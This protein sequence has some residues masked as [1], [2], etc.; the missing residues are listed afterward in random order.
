[1]KNMVKVI[2]GLSLVS[3]RASCAASA[4]ES[5]GTILRSEGWTIETRS[6]GAQLHCSLAGIRPELL[7]YY[8]NAPAAGKYE[9][10]ARVVTVTLDGSILLRL[11]RRTMVDIEVPYTLGKWDDT[12]PVTIDLKEGRNSL[13]FTIKPPNKGLTIKHF[14]LTPVSE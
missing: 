13:Q 12:K 3:V 6:D 5:D 4:A 14:K 1:M 10:T 8:V 11:N 7:K 2:T 9:L